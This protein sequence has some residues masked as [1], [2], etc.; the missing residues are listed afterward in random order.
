MGLQRRAVESAVLQAVMKPTGPLPVYASSR[1]ADQ[2]YLKVAGF[3]AFFLLS[4]PS[5]GSGDLRALSITVQNLLGVMI[6]DKNFSSF[7]YR[8]MLPARVLS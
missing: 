8:E 4:G 3:A 5:S 2:F 1:Q 6:T 7:V